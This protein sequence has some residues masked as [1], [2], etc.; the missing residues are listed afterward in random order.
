[1]TDFYAK[2]HLAFAMGIIPET[3]LKDLEVVRRVR[4]AFAHAPAPVRFSDAPITAECRKMSSRPIHFDKEKVLAE[5]PEIYLRSE[6]ENFM[7]SAFQVILD[8]I[9]LKMEREISQR[10][11]RHLNE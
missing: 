1:L 3:F 8:L 10:K 4:N 7:N 11:R 6:R 9:S 2:N 5:E